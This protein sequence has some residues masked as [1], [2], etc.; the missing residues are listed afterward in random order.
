M[1]YLYQS[2]RLETLAEFLATLT[3]AVPPGGVFAAETVIV[4]S[5]GMGRWLTFELARHNGIT[6][7]IDFVLPAAYA[8]RLMRQTLDNAPAL[9]PFSPD[10]L[11]WRLFEL[12]PT[13]D[14]PTFAPLARYLHTDS[15]DGAAQ[16]AFELAGKIAD[17]YDQYLMYRPH[18][19]QAWENGKRLDL[20]DDESWQAVLWQRL[21]AGMDTP[22]RATMLEHTLRGLNAANLPARIILFGIASLAPGYLA[23]VKRLAELTDVC[24]FT[25]N[26]CQEYWGDIVDARTQ[27]TLAARGDQAATQ[28]HP[29]LASLGKQGRDFFEL[30]SADAE[31]DSRGLFAPPP[32]DT[33]LTRLQH[34]ILTLSAPSAAPLA[35]DDA[36]IAVHVA[37]SPL[38]ELEILK[39]QLLAHFAADPT[40]TPAD[41][42]VLTPDIQTYAPFIHAVFAARQDTPGI[43][44]SIADCRVMR[45]H[46]LLAAFSSLLDL[47]D[48]RFLVDDVLALL[49]CAALRRRFAFSDEDLLLINRWVEQAAIRWGRD[50]AQRSALG[51]PGEAAFSWR[52][53]L[54]RL[55]LGSMLPTDLLDDQTPLFHGLL[56]LDDSGSDVALARFSTLFDTLAQ[57]ADDWQQPTDAA[58]WIT[59]LQQAQQ[60]LFAPDNSENAALALWQQALDDL[61]THT[62]LATYQ[63][64]FALGV[65]RDWLQRRLTLSVDSGFLN[66]G[67]TF[68]AM[69]PMRN[70]PFRLL[71]L[72]GLND[73][74]YPRDERPVSFD[75]IARQPQRGDRSR[76]DDDRYLFL[77]ALLSARETLYLSYV[78]RS[79][80]SNEPL[81]PSAL[82]S[83]LL[84]C[85]HTMGADSNRLITEH[86][87]QPFSARY[88]DGGDP[89]L[90]S[91]E[92]AYVAALQQ[93]MQPLAPF[94]QPLSIEPKPL[95]HINGQDLLQFWQSPARAWLRNRLDLHPAWLD[96]SAVEHEPFSLDYRAEQQVRHSLLTAKLERRPANT[97][98]R[99]LAAGGLLPPGEL[100][101]NYAQQ[102]QTQIR[103]LSL[104]SAMQ[105]TPLPPLRIQL[106]LAQY[107]IDGTLNGLRPEGAFMLSTHTFSARD[108]INAWLSHLLL[109]CLCPPEITP[110]TTL[111]DHGGS[112]TLPAIAQ[113]T[114]SALLLPWLR[115]WEQGQ[116]QPLPF[117]ARSSLAAAEALAA[118]ATAEQAR[119]K[120]MQKWQP[121]H[122]AAKGESRRAD[123]QLAFRHQQPLDE[124]LFLSLAELLLPMIEYL[125]QT[126]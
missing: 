69:V 42:A 91:Y 46:P 49:D 70:L 73:G 52:Q 56:P 66:G 13:L 97:V 72:I 112:V 88:Y 124:P 118:K 25:L 125:K 76:R 57:L 113:D 51:L 63:Q 85:L 60:Q 98:R 111:T 33:L 50:A 74:L 81:P 116:Q 7:N 121:A 86:P 95:V 75:L 44:Y 40:L 24:L 71:C 80:R 38:R 6:A 102:E 122:E 1:L 107:Q 62:G 21:T 9:S 28:G 83:E 100:G 35:N 47:L 12:L 41:V 101:E 20:G 18:W 115:Y 5:R 110:Q 34:D 103:R 31:L 82:V 99:Q 77:E 3:S 120:A 15:N 39:D 19:L 14:E 2:N 10:V 54:D 67:V 53:G 93:P 43:P 23:L 79:L 26:P 109:N 108:K 64:P 126:D 114:A 96:D 58:G 78:G 119:H 30:I 117:F 90:F 37:H 61:A 105:Q 8:W 92:P 17:V 89:R 59:R 65:L 27:A 123:I 32:A 106:Q 16:A 94:S 45:E 84:D 36:S 87:L 29:L 55:L 11:T 4:Q 22:H 48:S 104:P 68:C